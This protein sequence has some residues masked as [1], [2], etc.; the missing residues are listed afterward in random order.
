MPPPLQVLYM[1][2]PLD[3]PRMD[4]DLDTKLLGHKIKP[5]SGSVLAGE[6]PTGRYGYGS[7]STAIGTFEFGI[8]FRFVGGST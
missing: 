2:M 5:N 7:R 4:L 6:F 1:D 8:V 3:D